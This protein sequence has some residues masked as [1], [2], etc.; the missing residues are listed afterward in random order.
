MA[1]QTGREPYFEPKKD[2]QG[3]GLGAWAK[4]VQ[5]RREHPGRLYNIFKTRST[6][7]ACFSA[8]KGRLAYCVRSVTL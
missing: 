8:I 4:M 3:N 7:K 1:V 2:H 5:L 6:I